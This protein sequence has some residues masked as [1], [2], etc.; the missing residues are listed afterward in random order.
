MSE[1]LYGICENKCLKEVYP[2]KDQQEFTATKTVSAGTI[3]TKF[4]RS[5]NVVN[6]LTTVNITANSQIVT[7][8]NLTN[9]NLPDWAKTNQNAGEVISCGNF[10]ENLSA[11]TTSDKYRIVNQ[12]STKLTK[13]SSGNYLLTVTG[14]NKGDA[15]ELYTS[16]SYIVD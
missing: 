4:K 10:I 15:I 11:E 3:T 12:L 14:V 9:E 8:F 5:G 7:N 16:M 1:K 2:A 13:I 6:V